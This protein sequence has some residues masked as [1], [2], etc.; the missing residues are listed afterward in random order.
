MW[1]RASETD[2][3]LR[4][5]GIPPQTP[6][7]TTP[8]AASTP[9]FSHSA[10][11]SVHLLP[12]LAEA[13]Y[14]TLCSHD[15][16]PFTFTSPLHFHLPLLLR[17]PLPPP[18]KV[19]FI[20]VTTSTLIRDSRSTIPPPHSPCRRHPP[21][22]RTRVILANK[23]TGAFCCA[24]TAVVSLLWYEYAEVSAGRRSKATHSRTREVSLFGARH[25]VTTHDRPLEDRWWR[26]RSTKQRAWFL[27]Q[28]FSRAG[29]LISVS[30]KE[31]SLFLLCRSSHG[32]QGGRLVPPSHGDI[33]SKASLFLS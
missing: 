10:S 15:I 3:R 17:P 20:H 1:C 14:L 8:T 24:A 11:V 33:P 28:P 27:T 32:V 16:P 26:P 25:T 19:R 2:P 7:F 23:K 9:P 4:V 6:L 22:P 29:L 5:H 12:L 13:R 30:H 21:S 31:A 18:T